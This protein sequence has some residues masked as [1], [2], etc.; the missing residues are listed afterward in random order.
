MDSKTIS[1]LS[2]SPQALSGLRRVRVLQV[3]SM[4]ELECSC[5]GGCKECN[6]YT[7]PGKPT[8]QRYASFWSMTLRQAEQALDDILSEGFGE[9]VPPLFHIKITEKGRKCVLEITND[10]GQ[11][12]R[13]E[14]TKRG[15][16]E[17]E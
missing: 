2:N 8:F 12:V 6:D 4:L 15:G 17:H 3:L 7:P 1:H 16:H 10:I 9:A 13:S 11:F 5:S 14:R